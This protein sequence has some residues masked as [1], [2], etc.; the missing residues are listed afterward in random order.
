MRYLPTYGESPRRYKMASEEYGPC[1]PPGLSLGV[2]EDDPASIQS[3]PDDE[4]P[5]YGPCLPAGMVGKESGESRIIGPA[6][7]SLGARALATG[8]EGGEVNRTEESHLSEEEDENEAELIGPA[9][10][11]PNQEVCG[12]PTPTPTP[13]DVSV[14]I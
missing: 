5:S 3:R 4:P 11:G 7:P 1:L 9:L 10:P 2:V 14:T 6:L 13:A 8:E 12:R